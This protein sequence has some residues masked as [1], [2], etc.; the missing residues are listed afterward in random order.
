MKLGNGTHLYFKKAFFCF[1][2]CLT[3]W[4]S[5]GCLQ[6]YLNNNLSTRV[7]MVN[8]FE[9]FRPVFVVCPSSSSSYK[10]RNL[11]QLGIKDATTDK[12]IGMEIHLWM[13]KEFSNTLLTNSLI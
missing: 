11:K 8:S 2:L 9:T 12:E 10:L 3:M 4:R 13:E 7:K 6:K 5:Y 1:G